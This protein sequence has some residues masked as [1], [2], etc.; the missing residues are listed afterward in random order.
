MRKNPLGFMEDPI[1][2]MIIDAVSRIDKDYTIRSVDVMRE[3]GELR[4]IIEL[5]PR[6][7]GATISTWRIIDVEERIASLLGIDVELSHSRVGI[8]PDGYLLIV[9]TIKSNEIRPLE[10]ENY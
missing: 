2:S 6:R 7:E 4:I 8:S 5:R 9:Y 3:E 1:K 10:R